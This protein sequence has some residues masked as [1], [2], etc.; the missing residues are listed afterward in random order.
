MKRPRAGARIALVVLAALLALPITQTSFP[1]AARSRLRPVTKIFRNGTPIVV[2]A[3]TFDDPMAADP[4]PSEI[5]VGGFKGPIR[6]V[7]VRLENFVHFY[8]DD[9]QVLLVGPG[10]Q[11]AIVMANV[12]GGG[13]VAAVSLRLDDE[14]GDSLPD[15]ATLGSGRF[16]PTNA[17]NTIVEFIDL[18]P[19]ATANAAL[20]V[21]DG[22]NPNGTWRLFVQDEYAPTDAGA[23]A[24]GWALEIT[25]KAKAKKKKR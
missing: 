11:T 7:N 20:S 21:F 12:G 13:D 4:Y 18:P 3:D 16:R 17:T 24:G 25:A 8:P 14:A 6:D 9:V 19:L 5:A 2:R 23:F 15:D 22:T 1:V 10:G